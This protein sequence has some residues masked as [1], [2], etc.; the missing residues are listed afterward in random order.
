MRLLVLGV[1]GMLGS[2]LFRYFGGRTDLEVFGTVR[3]DRGKRHF[4]P[5]RHENIIPGVEADDVDSV[6]AAFARAR[7]NVVVNAVGLIKQ[8]QSSR[9]PLNALPLNSLFPHRLARLCDATGARLVHVSTDCVFAGTKGNYRESDTPDA[10]DLYGRSKLLGEVDY[11]HAI[12]LRTSI[13]GHE[14]DSA[15]GL[16]GW[17]LAQQG[18]VR[19]YS[20]AIF[21]GVPTVEL[22]RIIDC[23]VLPDAT[24]R[25][26]YHVASDPIS[27][28]NLLRLT[29]TAYHK[30]I[31]IVPDASV[32]IDRSLNADRFNEATGYRPPAWPDLVNDM[33]NFG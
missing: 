31:E 22:A 13:I 17:F 11:P 21:S 25:G 33:K 30:D 23:H 14:L 27:K 4:E 19:G 5:S 8:L 18:Q 1:T 28:L 10:T 16:I 24:L 29:A 15:N 7:P 9:D 12:T 26:L 3:S 6:I 32:A 20:R 2:T